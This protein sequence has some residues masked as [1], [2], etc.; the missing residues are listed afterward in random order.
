VLPPLAAIV[1]WLKAWRG[2][3]AWTLVAIGLFWVPIAYFPHSNIPTLLPTV[4][5]ERFWYLPVVGSSMLLALVFTRLKR[6]QPLVGMLALLGLLTFQALQG[7]AHALHY[8]NDLVFWRAATFAVPHS[9][10]ARLN[11]AVMVGA[12]GDLDER[13]KAGERAKRIAPDWPMAHVYH[14]DTL[15]RLGKARGWSAHTMAEKAWPEYA[16]GFELAPNDSNLIAL[17]LQCLWDQGALPIVEERLL[18]LSE[19]HPTSWLAYLADDIVE[20]G[21]QHNGVSPKY[22]PRGYNEGPKHR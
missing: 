4:R 9:A 13:L 6:K 2:Q 18:A 12:R 21:A 19:R 14:G 17:G 5:A 8:S 20:N 7:R 22:R 3:V 11:Y 15:C 1:C 10:K 16:R